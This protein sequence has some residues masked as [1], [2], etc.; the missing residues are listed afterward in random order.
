[1]LPDDRRS[2]TLR[3]SA[4]QYLVAVVFAALAVA[5][6]IFQIAQHDRFREIAENQ[7]LQR[8]PLQAPRGMVF[9]RYGK[10]LVENTTIRNIALVREQVKDLNATLQGLAAAVGGNPAEWLEIIQRK[11][12]MREPTYRPVVLIENAPEEQVIAVRARKLELRGI[13]DLPVPT[14]KYALAQMA[15]HL[16]GYVGE[17]REEQLARAENEGVEAGAIVG[18]AGV[19]Q[20]YNRLLMGTEGARNVIVNS[21]GREL[22]EVGTNPPVEG[23]RLQLTIDADLQKAAEDG[24]RHF[25]EVQS[26][27]PYNGAAVVIDPRSG[28]VLTFVSVPAFDPNK[29]AVRIDPATW[30]QLNTDKLRPLNNRVLQNRF[31]PGSTFKIVVATAALEE[32]VATPE[33][34][35]FCPGGAVFY[36]RYFKCHQAGGHGSVDMRHAIEKSCNVYF[37]TLGNMLG[38]DRIHKWA[39]HLG[40]ADKTGIDLPNEVQSIMPSTEWKRRVHKD[41]WYA[42]ETISVAI[43]Q[44]YVSV[45]PLSLAVMMMT[46]ANG[47]TR[48]TPHVLKAV[49]EGHGWKPVPPPPPKSVVKMKDS[50]VKALHDGLWMVV[51]AAGTG[52]RARLPGRD[53][54]GKTGTAQVISLEGAQKARGKMDVRDHGWYVFFAPRDNPELAGVV[55]TEHSQHGYYGGPIIKHIVETYYAKK[56]GKPLPVL[57]KPAAP[58][59]IIAAR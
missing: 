35:A 5:F 48:H 25:G 22:E 53:I 11:E 20:A 50:T 36:G 28:E 32:G 7:Y 14:R 30:K 42:G 19:E 59:T 51:N 27:G 39:A 12:R 29:F 21:K 15:A 55:F 34:R 6:W 52:G 58:A 49:D 44:G 10:V 47:G 1:M 26:E 4:M 31:S 56:E 8:L 40:L 18:Q 3:L 16:F 57:A 54:S 37:Y 43:G 41:K 38:I 45:T 17:V 13:I 46:I 33:F 24:F 2:L 23:R 9:D